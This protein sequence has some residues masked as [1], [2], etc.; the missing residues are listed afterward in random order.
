MRQRIVTLIDSGRQLPPDALSLGPGL[1][2]ESLNWPFGLLR[3][4]KALLTACAH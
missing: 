4:L 2:V 3:D 1:S